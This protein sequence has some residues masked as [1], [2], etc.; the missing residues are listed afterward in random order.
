MTVHE[1]AA[2]LH[3]AHESLFEWVRLAISDVIP[4][5][6]VTDWPGFAKELVLVVDQCFP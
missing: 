2:G 6:E 3:M 5:F 4:G 1:M